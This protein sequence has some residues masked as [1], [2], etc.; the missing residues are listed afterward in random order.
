MKKILISF[1]LSLIIIIST[2]DSTKADLGQGQIQLS[3]DSAYWFIQY[4]RGEKGKMPAAFYITTDGSLAYYWYCPY[5][6]CQTGSKTQEITLAKQ[7]LIKN[8]N[9]LLKEEQ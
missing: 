8:V 7:Q 6:N 5:G 9:Y 4:I 1:Y 3:D 2:N